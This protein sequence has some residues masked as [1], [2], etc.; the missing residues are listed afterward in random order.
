MVV[1]RGPAPFHPSTRFLPRTRF[2]APNETPRASGSLH[3][4][5]RIQA[6]HMKQQSIQFPAK[7]YYPIEMAC[8]YRVRVGRNRILEGSGSTS[9]ISSHTVLFKPWDP[10]PPNAKE[11]ELLIPWPVA[12]P[13]GTRLQLFLQGKPF[14]AGPLFGIQIRRYEFRTRSRSGLPELRKDPLQFPIAGP[15]RRLRQGSEPL[16]CSQAG[17]IVSIRTASA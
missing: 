7:S 12:L 11:I 16:S 8:S 14:W 6:M 5:L 15:A 13:D 3:I 17:R 1:F 10:I 2:L 4:V 9:Q